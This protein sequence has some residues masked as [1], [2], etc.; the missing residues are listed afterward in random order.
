[1]LR[2]PFVSSYKACPTP[3]CLL[4]SLS[5]AQISRRKELRPWGW[6]TA[7]LPQP[8]VSLL[9][10]SNL[11]S[12]RE[13]DSRINYFFHICSV[14]PVFS[15]N[16]CIN[17][18]LC[19]LSC[20]VYYWLLPLSFLYHFPQILHFKIKLFFRNCMSSSYISDIYSLSHTGLAD[21]FSH[22]VDCLFISLMVPFALWKLF[23]LM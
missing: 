16:S 17:Y 20:Q 21:I 2:W 12:L 18:S 9:A 8:G 3:E 10:P 23:S 4:S 22:S 14:L 6:I 5:S 1:M 19:L 13:E 7:P 11:I 15:G